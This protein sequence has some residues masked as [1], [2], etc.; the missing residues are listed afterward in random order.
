[1]FAALL[2]ALATNDLATRALLT[3]SSVWG[4]GG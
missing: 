1:M 3:L 2:S 4:W